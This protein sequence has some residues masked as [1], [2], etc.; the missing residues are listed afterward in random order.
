MRYEVVKKRMW[1]ESLIVAAVFSVIG[2]STYY[3]VT[4][5]DDYEE[6]VRVLVSQ[7]NAVQQAQN[8]LREKYAKVQKNIDIYQEALQKR[9]SNRLALTREGIRHQFDR[10]KTLYHLNNLRLTMQPPQALTDAKYKKKSGGVEASVVDVAFSAVTD[11]DV[12]DLLRGAQR[13]LPGAVRF[14]GVKLTRQGEATNEVLT[15]VGQT[16]QSPLVGGEI[17]FMWLGFKAAEPEG[18]VNAATP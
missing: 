5:L 14:T 13:S 18:G 15:I 17:Q 9:D 8:V 2:G 3:L 6:E 10:F 4:V 7:V 16:G 11:E 1:K 12:Y